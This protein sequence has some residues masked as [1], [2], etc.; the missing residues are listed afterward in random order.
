MPV[1]K[2]AKKKLKKDKARTRQNQ[3]LENLLK[4]AVKKAQK[5]KT[6]KLMKE[7][8]KLA[9]KATKKNIIHK[10]KA[11]RLKSKLS[12]LVSKKPFPSSAKKTRKT[13]TK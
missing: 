4:S 1:T 8:I 9:D 2:S 11:A 10:N 13:K 5:G 3:K 12:R 7:A 6:E